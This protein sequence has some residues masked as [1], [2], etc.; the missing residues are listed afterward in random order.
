[1]IALGGVGA[2]IL[3]FTAAE[4]RLTLQI[5]YATK[6]AG[7]T[8]HSNKNECSRGINCCA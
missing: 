1:M 8:P 6:H 4:Q 5:I 2:L 7:K 3:L